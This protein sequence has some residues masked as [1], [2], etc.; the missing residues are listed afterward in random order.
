LILDQV[1]SG[2][3]SGEDPD[4]AGSKIA[5]SGEDPDPARSYSNGSGRIRIRPDPK[6]WDP[7]HPYLSENYLK[8]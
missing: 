3:G 2:S 1:I 7:V 6:I 4:L 8:N 5:G